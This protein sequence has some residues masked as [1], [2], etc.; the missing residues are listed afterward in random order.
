M[1]QDNEEALRILLLLGQAFLPS[2]KHVL[3]M[4]ARTASTGG[5]T[6]AN[7]AKDRID[8]L[9]RLGHV[10][11]VNQLSGEIQT[12]DIT[13][14]IDREDI[15]LLNRLCRQA[16][17]GFA[18]TK[19]NTP[20]G[21]RTALQFSRVNAS[22]MEAVLNA[23]IGSNLVT[24]SEIAEAVTNPVPTGDSMKHMGNEWTRVSEGEWRHVFNSADGSAMV[25]TARADGSWEVRDKEI[26][27]PAMIGNETLAGV[28]VDQGMDLG[29]ALSAATANLEALKD[30]KIMEEHK[31]RMR[32]PEHQASLRSKD[33]IKSAEAVGKRSR[34]KSKKKLGNDRA[35]AVERD[36]K[37]RR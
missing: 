30:P 36:R 9:G 34:A 27:M 13:D 6:L 32:T 35:Y 14:G 15:R 1:A 28:A 12:L 37:V 26:D 25:A 31:R 5:L 29:G 8:G 22:T 23:A 4:L 11:S 24:E 2:A 18:V 33:V 20:N 7:A 19:L 10:R 3:L 16:G 21:T 17:C